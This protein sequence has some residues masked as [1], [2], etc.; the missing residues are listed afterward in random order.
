MSLETNSP[1]RQTERAAYT[2]PEFCA[3]YRV[4]RS[5]VYK[6]WAAGTGP[7]VMRLGAK[8]LISAEAAEDWRRRLEAAS[9]PRVA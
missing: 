4:S 3:T 2:F 7:R 5:A 6:M 1:A 9:A 8:I